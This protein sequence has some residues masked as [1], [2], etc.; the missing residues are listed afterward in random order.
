M[1]AHLSTHGLGIRIGATT[2]VDDLDLT[3]PSGEV[4]GLLGPNGSGKSTV[5]RTVYRSLAP[6][7]GTLRLDGKELTTMSLRESARHISALA[8][9]SSSDLDFTVE[10]VVRLGRTPH[11]KRGRSLTRG[12][13]ELTEKT[14]AQMDILHLRHRGILSLSGGERQRVLIAR[15]L[16]QEPRLLVLDEPTNHLDIAHQLRLLTLLR[17][18][19]CTVLTV[20]HDL[21]LAA[22]ACD[23]IY[24]L[25]A[26]HIVASGPPEDVITPET[27]R[28]VYGIDV[29]VI[30]HPTTRRP[31]VLHT[32]E[33]LET[34]T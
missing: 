20:L 30:P 14:M 11:Q 7:R 29:L 32:L 2:I 24:L 18:G 31:Q 4:V 34:A 13:L 5:L 33:S 17:S 6:S 16:V 21:N 12:E 26:G 25:D 15:A 22:A 10:E 8:Q 27:I 3:V 9:D 23:R 1:T 28:T 19:I